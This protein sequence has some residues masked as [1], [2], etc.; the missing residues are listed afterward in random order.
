MYITAEQ[1]SDWLVGR[2]RVRATKSGKATKAAG[3]G[4]NA[5]ATMEPND[6]NKNNKKKNKLKG[7]ISRCSREGENN[8]LFFFRSVLF[9]FFS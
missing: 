3:R 6:S 7:I 4:Y 1:V 2:G 5:I 9:Y 8:K